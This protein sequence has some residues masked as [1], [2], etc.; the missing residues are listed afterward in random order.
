MKVYYLLIALLLIA[1]I[2][3]STKENGKANVDQLHDIWALE[4]INGEPFVMDDQTRN[5]PVIEIY[6]QENRIHGNTGCN[7]INGTIKIDNNKINFSKLMVTQMACPG[8]LEYRLLSAF[9]VIDNYK[10]ENLRLYLYEGE[11]EKLV[12]RKVD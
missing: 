2:C 11:K 5:Y 4:S 10:V 1:A 3:C 6:T 12:F 9:E 7:T 8:D